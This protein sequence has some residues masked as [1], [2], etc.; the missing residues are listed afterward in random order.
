MVGRRWHAACLPNTAHIWS[1]SDCSGVPVFWNVP[2]IW[3][4]PAF[5]ISLS[6]PNLNMLTCPCD[7]PC[8]KVRV[9]T[10]TGQATAQCARAHTQKHGTQ[11]MFASAASASV[12]LAMAHVLL[13]HE[14]T[15][16]PFGRR[17]WRQT[18]GRILPRWR[19]VCLWGHVVHIWSGGASVRMFGGELRMPLGSGVWFGGC[20]IMGRGGASMQKSLYR[21]CKVSVKS[22]CRRQWWQVCFQHN[23]ATPLDSLASPAHI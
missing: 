23:I 16:F 21:H 4:V 11:I 7:S 18:S 14:M 1:G 5:W 6:M 13:P 3:V 20:K 8:W 9:Q 22:R 17:S 12:P 15:R 2:V 10:A 19:R